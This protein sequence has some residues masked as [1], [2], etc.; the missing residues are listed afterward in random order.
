M[1]LIICYLHSFGF[2]RVVPLL[3][4]PS[5]L[6]YPIVFRCAF[7]SQTTSGMT[8]IIPLFVIILDRKFIP[9]SASIFGLGSL[10]FL[11]YTLACILSLFSIKCLVDTYIVLRSLTSSSRCISLMN[12]P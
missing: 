10:G 12:L 3:A 4:G 6:N 9:L 11:V 5:F 7:E 8:L 2:L 1:T